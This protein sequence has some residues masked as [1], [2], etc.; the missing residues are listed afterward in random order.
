MGINY[1]SM[2]TLM[3]RH[4]FRRS[5]LLIDLASEEREKAKQAA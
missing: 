3:I 2:V 5:Q 4:G 1:S